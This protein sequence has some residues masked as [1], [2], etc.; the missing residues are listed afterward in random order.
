MPDFIINTENDIA[1]DDYKITVLYDEKD[2]EA[3]L[4]DRLLEKAPHYS[5]AHVDSTIKNIQRTYSFDGTSICDAFQEIGEEIGC[6][7]VYNS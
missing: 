3:S 1:R 6:L 2:K 4:L 7:F 5:I